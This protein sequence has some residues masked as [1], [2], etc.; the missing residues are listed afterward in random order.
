MRRRGLR[1]AHHSAFLWFGAVA[2]ALVCSSALSARAEPGFAGDLAPAPPGDPGHVV[3]APDVRGHHRFRLG[4]VADL[5]RDTFVIVDTDR[6]VRHVIEQQLWLH[7]LA[8]YAFD[9]RL[10]GVIGIPALVEQ[11]GDERTV[12]TAPVAQ[13]DAAPAIGDLRFGVRLRLFGA[14][15][16]AF[17]IAAAA[18]AFAPTGSSAPYVGEGAFRIRPALIVGRTSRGVSWSAEAGTLLREGRRYEGVLPARLGHAAR[19]GGGVHVPV[20]SARTIHVGTEAFA[21]LVLAEGARLLDPRSTRLEVL[22]GPR[23]VPFGGAFVF[24]IAGGPGIGQAPGTADFRVLASAVYSPE[25]PPKLA[26]T[27]DDGIVDAE[28]AC[29]DL[30]GERSGDPLMHGCPPLPPDRDDDSIPDAFDACPTEPGEPTGRPKTHGCPPTADS[31]GDG[32]QDREDA[33]PA[34]PGVPNVDLRRHGCPP[35]PP[36]A[37]LERERI[38]ITQQVQFETGTAVIVAASDAILEQVRLVL[39]QHREIE[40]VEVQG[41]TDT[42]GPRELNL[43]LSRE[44][45]EAVVRWLVDRGV[46][47]ARL[48][49]QGYGPDQ[50][51]ADNATERGRG[52]NRRVEFRIVR[53]AGTSPRRQP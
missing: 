14:P 40:L 51:I 5:S 46:A 4:L 52:L 45:A 3:A 27:D 1:L 50:P 7:A 26:D 18:D 25:A 53:R 16:D 15:R 42:T 10:L 49:S 41:H 38:T 11:S 9:E 36:R 21:E 39:E 37:E 30:A 34:V 31:D 8:S 33:C 2:G 6:Q 17:S 20:N 24:G 28:D 32:I 12:G 13:S 44:R 19:F 35:P 23:I 47:P 22:L 48:Q 29:V 43:R